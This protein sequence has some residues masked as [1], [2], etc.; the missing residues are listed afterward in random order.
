MIETI[1]SIPLIPAHAIP[2]RVSETPAE[3]ICQQHQQ[4][5]LSVALKNN[6]H[7]ILKLNTIYSLSCIHKVAM[8]CFEKTHSQENIQPFVTSEVKCELN[9][10]HKIWKYI[11]FKTCKAQWANSIITNWGNTR[12]STRKHC[13]IS[14]F[15]QEK[16]L[17]T[18]TIPN[19]DRHSFPIRCELKNV[20]YL[21]SHHSPIEVN[22]CLSRCLVI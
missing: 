21:I 2:S 22:F 15:G 4:T 3:H 11:G 14:A 8:F 6:Y 1:Q 7:E 16:N 17:A 10:C 20:E 18:L 19:N 5:S 13:L 12:I 9:L